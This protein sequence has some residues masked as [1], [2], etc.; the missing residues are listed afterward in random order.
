MQLW[1]GGPKFAEFNVGATIDSYGN[2]TSGTESTSGS[3]DYYNTANCGGLYP[4]NN[5]NKNGRTETWTSS[6]ATGTGDV[7]TTNWGSN[8]TTPTKD[9]LTALLDGLTENTGTGT[10]L[11]LVW[12]WMDGSTSQ[13]VSGCTLEGYKISG[14]AGTVYASNSIF[15]PKAGYYSY[16]NT[17]I[18]AGAAY[19]SSTDSSESGHSYGLNAGEKAV[20]SVYS[21]NGRSIRA[22]LAE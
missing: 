1:E 15:L 3:V 7:A 6:V 12:E 9:Q 22:I 10:T 2:L 16:A 20:S 5:P 18:K 4:W 14:K 21:G 19:W 11:G 17:V 8:W 13:Y